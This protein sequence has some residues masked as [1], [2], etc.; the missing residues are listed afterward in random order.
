MHLALVT[1]SLRRNRSATSMTVK[2]KIIAIDCDD[3]I[4]ETSPYLIAYYNERYGTRLELK[5]MYTFNLVAYQAASEE[6]VLERIEDYLLTD[7][8]QRIQ[9]LKETITS[10][11]NIAN[12]YQ[13]HIVTGR[14]K[15]LTA[16][17]EL[18]IEKYFP[19]IFASI[20]HTGMVGKRARS[21]GDVCI[22]LDADLL[23][24]DHLYHAKQVAAKSIDVLLFGNYPW[25][26]AKVLP[27][28]I[29]RVENWSAIEKILL[30]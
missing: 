10:I 13:L 22:D 6:Q 27:K 16:T 26:Q 12:S 11:T 19:G 8:F 3:V 7:E 18:L 25:N 5:D 15:L 28:H 17:T 1:R 2:R 9:P 23:I 4:L 29:T 21:K 30:A 14:S 20:E 24:E